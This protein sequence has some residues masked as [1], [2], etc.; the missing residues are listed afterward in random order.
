MSVISGECVHFYF[1]GFRLVD[2]LFKLTTT[3]AQVV[4]THKD[5]FNGAVPNK[6]RNKVRNL[7]AEIRTKVK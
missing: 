6:N 1:I 7:W 5:Y 4:Y 2:I 3:Y